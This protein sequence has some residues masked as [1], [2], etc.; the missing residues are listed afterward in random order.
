[1]EVVSWSGAV[2][3]LPV[4]VSVEM[5]YRLDNIRIVIS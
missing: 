1:M 2:D 4:G 5:T 3:N